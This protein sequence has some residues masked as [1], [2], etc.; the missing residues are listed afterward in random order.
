MACRARTK[1]PVVVINSINTIQRTRTN[2]VTSSININNAQTNLNSSEENMTVSEIPAAPRA[3]GSNS[4][5]PEYMIDKIL[6]KLGLLTSE[7]WTLIRR[8]AGLQIDPETAE[9]LRLYERQLIFDEG[10]EA[11]VGTVDLDWFARN[12]GSDELVWVRDLPK[13][14]VDRLHER[15]RF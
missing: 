14:T 11:N 10:N 5:N 2:T 8:V 3:E 6:E 15:H 9:V 4:I 12:P 7:Q 13:A 1:L